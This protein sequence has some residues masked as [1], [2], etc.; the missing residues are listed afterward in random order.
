MENRIANKVSNYSRKFKNDV[1]KEIQDLQISFEE[2]Q[3]II[4]YV[5]DYSV[6]CLDKE[7]FAKR[8]RVKNIVS[9]CDRCMAK[10]AEGEQC[11]RKRKG[12]SMFCGTHIKG[13][14]HGVVEETDCENNVLPQKQIQVTAQEIKG[15][16]YYLDD[17]DNVYKA[18]DILQNKN[19]PQIIAKYTKT[20]DGNYSIPEYNI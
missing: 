17:N 14:P 11:T 10:R 5:Y 16:I 1:V 18:E 19:N 7:D 4:Q 6:L 20:M 13:T 2:K 8:K 9:F 15:I 3:K 12:D